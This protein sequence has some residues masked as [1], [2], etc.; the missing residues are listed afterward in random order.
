MQ[1]T[2]ERL[3]SDSLRFKY[4]NKFL[5][6]K[7]ILDLAS[8]EG[9]V[10][11]LLIKNNPD[12]KIYSCDFKDADFNRNLN[13]PFG[14][15]RKFDS[16]IAGEIIEHV[17]NPSQFLRECKKLLVKNGRLI[18]TTPNAIGLQYI[19]NPAWCIENYDKPEH[20]SCFTM[21][22]LCGLMAKIGYKV[23]HADYINAFWI[24]NPLQII[25]YLIRRLRP[26]LLIVAEA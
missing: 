9:Y 23:I 18:I 15:N 25:P 7:N 22:M 3:K 16:V 26:D 10:H 13:E 6:G 2:K 1:M 4:I 20:I 14:I 5:K 8:S 24:N 11:E 19:K 12:K 21:P 17:E